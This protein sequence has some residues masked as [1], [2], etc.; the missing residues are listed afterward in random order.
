MEKCQ[1]E[2]FMRAVKSNPTLMQKGGD[3]L[4]L[5][6]NFIVAVNKLEQAVKVTLLMELIV[7]KWQLNADF[8]SKMIL[9]WAVEKLWP[10]TLSCV[11]VFSQNLNDFL[12]VPERPEF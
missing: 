5:P 9:K 7:F 6:V 3:I 12:W 10:R 8:L 1:T 2:L 4:M 11:S